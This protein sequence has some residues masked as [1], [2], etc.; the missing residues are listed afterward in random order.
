MEIQI[1]KP[2]H[3]YK[4]V[5]VSVELLITALIIILFYQL[6]VLLFFTCIIVS[7]ILFTDDSYCDIIGYNLYKLNFWHKYLRYLIAILMVYLLQTLCV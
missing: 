3:A 5:I 1:I 7:D 2:Q 6:C 4:K